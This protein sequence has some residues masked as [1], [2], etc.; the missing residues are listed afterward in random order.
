MALTH[1]IQNVE[2]LTE[3]NYEFWKLQMR[4]ILVCNDLWE[5]VSDG[6]VK[7][8]ENAGL[9]IIKSE[10]IDSIRRVVWTIKLRKKD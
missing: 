10:S 6:I 4:S 9:W 5:Y 8:E 7:T 1:G 3:N 2:K